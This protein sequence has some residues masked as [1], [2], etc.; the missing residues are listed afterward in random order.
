MKYAF[1][2]AK[3]FLSFDGEG[4]DGSSGGDQT[5]S[6]AGDRSSGNSGGDARFTQDD[7]N[8][9]VA[10]DKR[11]HQAQ[12]KQ[13]EG[14]LESL[15]QDK[16]LTDTQRKELKQQLEDL[17]KTYRTK[18]QQAEF[19]RKQ[20]AEKYENE[21][22]TATARAERW[23]QLYRDE[24]VMRSLQDAAGAADAFNP[25]QIVGLLKPFTVLKELEGGGLVPMIDFPD[26]D[27]KTGEEIKTL[28]TPMDAV[29]RMKKLPKMYGNLFKS[30]VVSGV[31]AGQGKSYNS[32]DLDVKNLT[33]EEYMR[34]R[35]ENP[36]KLG[37]RRRPG[38]R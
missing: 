8:R 3:L 26:V 9:I 25:Q 13:L 7:V 17:Q 16:S 31:G 10:E 12:M 19:E 33:T 29:E 35:R 14:K 21:L 36:E 27:E 20:A 24:K 4:D 38:A 11:K 5:G 6:G 18:E 30:N 1:P 15:A 32:D 34:L 28:R 23:E 2:I 22:K 37:L